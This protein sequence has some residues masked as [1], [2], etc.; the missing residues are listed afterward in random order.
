MSATG[1][2]GN[3]VDQVGATV[4]RGANMMEVL[5]LCGRYEVECVGPVETYRDMYV[6]VRD[7]IARM[8]EVRR[9]AEEVGDQARVSSCEALLASLRSTMLAIPMEKKWADH[10]DNL[11][12]TVGKNLILDTILAGSSFTAT[13]RMGLK[14][15]GSA[16]AGD[17]Q[18]SHGGWTERGGANAPAYTGNRPT[19]S[20]NAAS[21]GTK[22]TSAAVSFAITSSG[23]VDGC[24]INING[25][26][27]KDDTT[28]TL[29][30][31][32]DFSGGAKTVANGDTLNVTYSLSV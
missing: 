2:R 18:A 14:G 9:L 1:E 29:L 30:S 13:T 23:N 12:T 8:E 27:T 19:P 24:F 15:A 6:N 32:G 5:G 10:I 3:A 21:S 16:A 22:S 25:S 7:E 20:F 4:V 17:T 28:G 31:A 26:A 11:V